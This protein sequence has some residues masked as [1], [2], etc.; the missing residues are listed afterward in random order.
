M[1]TLCA[2]VMIVFAGCGPTVAPSSTA[3]GGIVDCSSLKNV[4]PTSAQHLSSCSDS[5]C[6]NTE[7]LPTGGDHCSSVTACRSHST[8]Q[9]RCQWIH[10]MEHGHV[11]LLFNCPSGCPEIVSELEALRGEAKKGSNGV[12]RALVTPDSRITTKVAAAVW[13]WSWTGDSVDAAAIR[14]L[15]TKQDLN[16]PEPGLSCAP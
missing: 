2:F 13:G 16:A 8:E 6:G 7:N 1:R 15:I 12:A 10:N 11:A 9:L 14:C 3:D 5:A 4:M